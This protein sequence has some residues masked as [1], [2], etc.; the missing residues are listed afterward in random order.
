MKIEENNEANIVMAVNNNTI[1][2]K[3]KIQ[4]NENLQEEEENKCRRLFNKMSILK[5]KVCFWPC[6]FSTVQSV[7][8]LGK[9]GERH[10]G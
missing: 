7:F 3:K 1:E 9:Y 5:Y 6:D 10:H 8:W 4:M 2:H